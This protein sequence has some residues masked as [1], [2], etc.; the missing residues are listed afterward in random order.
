MGFSSTVEAAVSLLYKSI[1]DNHTNTG[2]F[3]FY[4]LYIYSNVCTLFGPPLSLVLPAPQPYS[5]QDLFC[6]LVLWFSNSSSERLNAGM[7][8][9]LLSL[10]WQVN[11]QH[12]LLASVV[13]LA[14]S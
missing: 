7:G 5:R 1:I 8:A 12:A 13:L 6:P 2:S 3:F 14:L 9:S 4:C 11:S 10:R